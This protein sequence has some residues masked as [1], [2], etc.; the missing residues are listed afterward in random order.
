MSRLVEGVGGDYSYGSNMCICFVLLSV[1]VS[2]FVFVFVFCCV[3]CLTVSRLGVGGVRGSVVTI[4]M[5]AIPERSHTVSYTGQPPIYGAIYINTLLYVEL[6]SLLPPDK[7]RGETA[8]W[9]SW[10][11]CTQT[12]IAR[13]FTYMCVD[14]SRICAHKPLLHILS[15]ICLSYCYG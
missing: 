13:T 6:A 9:I 14:M 10:A 2:V 1:F 3:A 4:L 7:Q 11:M 5:A 12:I 8:V 15:Q